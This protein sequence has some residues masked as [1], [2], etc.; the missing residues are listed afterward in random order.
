MRVL[1]RIAN[2]CRYEKTI[3]D[4]EV[5][6]RLR[7]P[8]IDCLLMRSRLRYLARLF[9]SSPKSLLG[10]LASRPRGQMLTWSKLILSD[11]M[12]LRQRVSLCSRLPDPEEDAS[13]WVEFIRRGPVAWSLAVKTLHFIESACDKHAMPDLQCQLVCHF[14]CDACDCAFPTE[15]AKKAHQRTKHKVL[16][17]QRHY[18]DENG[19]CPVCST[20]FNTRLR[21]LAHL[22]DSRRPKCW[23]RICAQ[24]TNFERLSDERTLELDAADRV[25]RREARRAGYSHPIAIGPARTEAGKLIGH[26]KL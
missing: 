6:K 26:V 2:A 22:C 10:L 23:D 14:R 21:L 20:G 19:V 12:V 25:S 24:P 16:V 9:S 8:S 11:L 17:P 18:A 15:K 4:Y 7:A 5:R 1:R 3:P 13:A